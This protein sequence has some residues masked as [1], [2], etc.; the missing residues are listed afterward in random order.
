MMAE[1]AKYNADNAR[2]DHRYQYGLPGEED[3]QW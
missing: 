2:A 1:A 3:L